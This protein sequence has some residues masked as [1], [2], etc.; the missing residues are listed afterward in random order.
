VPNALFTEILR[1]IR[2]RGSVFARPELRAPW[3]LRV[4]DAQAAFHIV[5]RG[6]CRLELD[7]A[8]AVELSEGDFV[9]LPRG[10]AYVLRDAPSTRPVRLDAAL[11]SRNRDG[12][13]I[14]R[15]GGSGEPTV[16]VCGNLQFEDVS[17][18]LLLSI[19]PPLIHMPKKGSHFAA[20]LGATIEHIRTD[21]AAGNAAAEVVVARIADILF[22]QA[23]AM[24]LEANAGTAD[25]GWLAALRDRQIGPALTLLHQ[26]PGQTWTVDSLAEELG[27]SRSAFAARFAQ[28]VGEPPL[29][30]LTRV[31]LHAAGTRLSS[32]DEKM[33]SIA[34]SLGYESAS[35]FTKAFKARFGITPGEYRGRFAARTGA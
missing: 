10:G 9:V 23:V 2:V 30:Y 20:W 14:F 4:D 22:I 26:H 7:G 34:T 15:L 24:Y 12:D 35:G 6:R 32:S 11:K 25:S 31:R 19:L 3:G 1:S 5:T 18:D 16:L 21:L 28:L 29:R 8:E 33:T 13:G 27:L 17:T